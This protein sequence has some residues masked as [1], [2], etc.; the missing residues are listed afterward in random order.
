MLSCC[1]VVALQGVVKALGKVNKQLNVERD[2]L[3]S[4]CACSNFN[5]MQ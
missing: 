1:P 4:C 2:L 3:V 5:S